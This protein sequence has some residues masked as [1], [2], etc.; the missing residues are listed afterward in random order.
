MLVEGWGRPAAD[1]VMGGR[2][3][4][5]D[6]CKRE[7]R[8][9]QSYALRV[10]IRDEFVELYIDD[11]WVSSRAFASMAANGSVEWY[12]E[13]GEAVFRHAQAAELAPLDG[14]NP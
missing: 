6:I 1:V 5:F 11:T 9:E 13:R 3:R 7:L 4:D 8:Y 14:P 12:V 10:V 2:V